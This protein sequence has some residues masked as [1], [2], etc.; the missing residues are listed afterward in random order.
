MRLPAT[1]QWHVDQIVTPSR[2]VADSLQPRC[3]SLFEFL[4]CSST[5]KGAFSQ[6]GHQISPMKR[7]MPSSVLR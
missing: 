3:T 6:L 7:S 2:V 5:T 4:P 1:P